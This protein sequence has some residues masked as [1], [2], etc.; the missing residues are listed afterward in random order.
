MAVTGFRCRIDVLMTDPAEVQFYDSKSFAGALFPDAG[1]CAD[2]GSY[3]AL[4]R[5]ITD[6][7]GLHQLIY[8]ELGEPVDYRIIEANPAYA[9]LLGMPEAALLGQTASTLYGSEQV[10]DLDMY[11]RVIASGEPARFEPR[12][13]TANRPL[14]ATVYSLG[15][16]CCALM[17]SDAS[18]SRKLEQTLWEMTE[19]Y[20]RLYHN[21]RVGL[22]L[23]RRTDGVVLECNAYF[24]EILGYTQR[25]A[26][27][28]DRI[29]A[30]HFADP[31]VWQTLQVALAEYGEVTDLEMPCSREDGSHF[32]ARLTARLADDPECIEGCMLDITAEQLAR[33][34][35][36]ESE[37]RLRDVL[38]NVQLLSMMIDLDGNILFCNDFFLKVIGCRQEEVRGQHIVELLLPPGEREEVA[39][40]L[41][42]MMDGSLPV[43]P[44]QSELLTRHGERRLINWSHSLLRNPC[45]EIIGLAG[46]GE[47]I[48]ERQRAGQALQE[49][50]IRFRAIF[51]GATTGIALTDLEGRFLTANPALQAL[52]G[53]SEAEL[54]QN[55]VRMITLPDDLEH[56]GTCL[57]EVLAKQ[58]DSYQVEKRFRRKD[59]G[60]IWG[61]LSISIVRDEHGNPRFSIEMVD[62]IT[63]RK[64]AEEELLQSSARFER[65]MEGAVTALATTTEWRDAYTAGHQH[66]VAKLACAIAQE[67]GLSS[68]D[69]QGIRIGG[70]L[71]DIGK[72]AV[73]LEILCKPGKLTEYEFSI[74]RT[75]PQVGY[76]ILQTVDFPWPIAD[77]VLQHHFRLNGS[78]YPEG[79]RAEDILREAK[80]LAVADV[81]E[82]ISSYRPYRGALGIEAA[83]AEISHGAGVAF[84]AETVAAC[85]RI[86]ARGQF[87]FEGDP[88]VE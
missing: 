58:L 55:D 74:I 81:V 46:I 15:N 56:N 82:A 37:R 42:A 52:L 12:F 33:E 1:T 43:M 65:A 59:G 57:A 3:R 60:I 68:S 31:K 32:L 73:P 62:N 23:L 63:E 6:G 50:E 72:I 67:M 83:L 9:A 5:L 84:D 8:D 77:M 22:Y 34:A 30:E 35:L 49:S 26:L 70:L 21:A 54:R 66:R 47:D 38:E 88:V 80:I 29:A 2:A 76:E 7:I 17:L 28:A 11:A 45:G 39:S 14:S 19:R 71:H 75:H 69:I 44:V 51:E 40:L 36:V 86:F 10:P 53:Y 20:Q 61:R 24:A 48:T 78:G 87:S 85:L 25:E 79:L 13:P 16:G 41:H 18:A 4:F 27:F 64:R